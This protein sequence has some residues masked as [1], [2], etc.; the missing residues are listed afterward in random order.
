VGNVKLR[1]HVEGEEEATRRAHVEGEGEATRHA[2]AEGAETHRA[3]AEGAGNHHVHAGEEENPR[4]YHDAAAGATHL[5]SAEGAEAIGV[6][7]A[8][9]LYDGEEETRNHRAGTHLFFAAGAGSVVS[10]ASRLCGAVEIP[11]RPASYHCVAEMPRRGEAGS[12]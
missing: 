5:S 12:G 11:S 4:A 9:R 7:E 1:A 10:G 8:S 3:R 2:H 6:L